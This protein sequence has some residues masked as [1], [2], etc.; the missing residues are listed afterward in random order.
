MSFAVYLYSKHSVEHG[1]VEILF[2]FV[3]DVSMG[4]LVQL[5]GQ[6]PVGK[7]LIY[8]PTIVETVEAMSHSS[9]LKSKSKDSRRL[10]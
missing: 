9:P 4:Y 2:L 8:V 7:T 3:V 5:T 1:F 6:H 10:P